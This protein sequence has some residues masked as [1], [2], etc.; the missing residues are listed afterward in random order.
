[1]RSYSA[2]HVV[3]K[4]SQ[5]TQYTLS[6]LLSSFPWT[7]QKSIIVE[8]S[9]IVDD[10]AATKDFY[11]IK[12][13]NSRNSKIVELFCGEV[14]RNLVFFPTIFAFIFSQNVLHSYLNVP[15]Y[16]CCSHKMIIWCCSQFLTSV[17]SSDL[18]S[19]RVT[20]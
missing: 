13:H 5:F 14:A 11:L 3:N 19:L 20:T 1:M 8:N 18:I 17:N 10:L 4:N 7:T 12:I 6:A 2:A 16:M 15:P 9:K